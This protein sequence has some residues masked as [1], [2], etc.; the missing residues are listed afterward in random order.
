MKQNPRP[1]KAVAIQYNRQSERLKY[2][3]LGS[4]F[5]VGAL[6][7]GEALAESHENTTVSHGYV[8]FG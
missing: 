3:L 2:W 4:V 1:S 7:A 8:N 5:T 6:W